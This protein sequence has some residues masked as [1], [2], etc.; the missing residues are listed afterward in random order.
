MKAEELHS[1]SDSEIIKQQSEDELDHSTPSN[2]CLYFEDKSRPIQ[3]GIKDEFLAL[4][5]LS[6]TPNSFYASPNT[7]YDQNY[8]P[9]NGDIV[10]CYSKD[11]IVIHFFVGDRLEH[12]VIIPRLK[13][14]DIAGLI[15]WMQSAYGGIFTPRNDIDVAS[16]ISEFARTPQEVYTYIVSFS[17]YS[18]AERLP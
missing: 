10:C 18:I 7:V 12:G 14:M 3:S 16:L 1:L 11:S 15:S 6:T 4:F 2:I 17:S 9:S 5:K 13:K 8:N